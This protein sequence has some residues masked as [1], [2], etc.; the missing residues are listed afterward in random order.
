MS[1][2]TKEEILEWLGEEDSNNKV[3]NHLFSVD[4]ND[5]VRK[6]ISHL[7]EKVFEWQWK[8]KKISDDGWGLDSEFANCDWSNLIQEIRDFGKED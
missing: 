7:I 2:P 4:F 8:A 5:F 3:W 6:G 1:E